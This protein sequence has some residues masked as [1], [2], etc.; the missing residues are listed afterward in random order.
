ME[1]AEHEKEK[2]GKP[3]SLKDL[4]SEKTHAPQPRHIV[5]FTV[6]TKSFINSLITIIIPREKWS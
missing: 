3:A 1:K 4:L 5:G 2:G 6:P